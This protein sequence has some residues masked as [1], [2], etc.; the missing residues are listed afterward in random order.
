MGLWILSDF[1]PEA[2]PLG[3]KE[4][5]Y[6]RAASA[7]GFPLEDEPPSIGPGLPA[8][9]VRIWVWTSH[10]GKGPICSQFAT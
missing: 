2:E 1:I 10:V 3:S 6:I 9:I 8:P 5:R 4:G 7:I